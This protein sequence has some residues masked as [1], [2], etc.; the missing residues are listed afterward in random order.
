M[1]RAMIY[2]AGDRV[3]PYLPSNYEV[4]SEQG[5]YC[6]VEGTDRA[7]WTMD[8]Y[9]LPRLATGLIFGTELTPAA[10][11]DEPPHCR[12][13]LQFRSDCASCVTEREFA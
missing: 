9:V 10:G 2:A 5:D 12:T 4:T 3:R 8:D 13:H 7:G 1:R 11:D 6:I